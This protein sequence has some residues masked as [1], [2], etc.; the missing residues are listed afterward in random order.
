[1]TDPRPPDA[2][3]DGRWRPLAEAVV[4]LA[5]TPDDEAA[6]DELLIGIAVSAADLIAGVVYASVTAWR[7]AGYTT[8]AASS[9]LARAVD[10]AQHAE[11]SGPCVQAARTGEPVGVPDIA[12]TMAWPGFYRHATALGL[13]ASVSVPLF[14]GGGV[15][16][17]VLNL[18][19]REPSAL[20]D[21]MTGVRAVFA[22]ERLSASG[23]DSGAD[24]GTRQLLL[25]LGL[26]LEIRVTIQR[27]LGVL[28]AHDDSDAA[29]ARRMLT[30]RA[31]ARGTSL[32]AT[33]RQVLAEV[34]PSHGVAITVTTVPATGDAVLVVL[35]GEL[36]VPL[37]IDV[38]ER[39]TAVLDQPARVLNLDLTG[40]RFCDLAGLRS[41][42]HLRERAVAADRV[43]RVVAA[44]SAVRLLMQVT[45]TSALF[46]YSPASAAENGPSE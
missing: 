45:D 33:A 8:V 3:D 36:A 23:I 30:E 9:D 18:Y 24:A 4:A 15:P 39:L 2:S 43:V 38:T 26:A 41:L 6:V 17:G 1:M 28:M 40:L 20:T 27:A 14:A 16:V 21:L 42:L 25:G 10:D 19:G 34:V 46:G 31:A 13:R 32:S 29:E 37:E 12:A 35:D 44:S 22:V 7:G 11:E 5:D